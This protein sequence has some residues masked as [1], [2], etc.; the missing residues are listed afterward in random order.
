VV[1][2][3]DVQSFAATLPGSTEALARGRLKLR[4]GRYVYAAFSADETVMGFGF[5]KEFRDA[6]VESEPHKFMLPGRGRPPV[7]LGPR[8]AGGARRGGDARA[9][10]RRLGDVRA[11][12]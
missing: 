9:G 7:Q 8:P 10:D 5:P 2:V 4:A 1:T 11:E 6:L 12:A 3:D